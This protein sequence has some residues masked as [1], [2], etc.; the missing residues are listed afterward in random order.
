MFEPRGSEIGHN[1]GQRTK[2]LSVSS[3][4]SS[5]PPR[6]MYLEDCQLGSLRVCFGTSQ[7]AC[8]KASS[9][10]ALRSFGAMLWTPLL[11]ER[12]ERHCIW[13]VALSH[14]EKNEF[15]NLIRSNEDMG[16]DYVIELT[17]PTTEEIRN[18]RPLSTVPTLGCV[19][20]CDANRSDT[21]C[22]YKR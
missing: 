17:S 7:F 9:L 14:E 8:G 11:P 21:V 13:A 6:H 10:S 18:A 4:L 12:G 2:G 20:P 22:G 5:Y 1:F 19:H 16:N 3:P 15:L